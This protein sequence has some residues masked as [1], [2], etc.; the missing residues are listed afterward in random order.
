MPG[1]L[2]E[3]IGFAAAGDLCGSLDYGQ[4][5]PMTTAE[6]TRDVS[7]KPTPKLTLPPLTALVVGSVIG[8]ASM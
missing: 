3:P 8:G 1:A 7:A 2:S 4:A 5:V 6:S